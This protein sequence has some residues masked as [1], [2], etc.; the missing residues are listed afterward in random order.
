MTMF[1]KWEH[2]T[3]LQQLQCEFSDLY[4]DVY[5]VRPHYVCGVDMD[6]EDFLRKE[7]AV[8]TAYLDDQPC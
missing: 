2:M 7:I 8:L 4:K 1:T 5:G 3:P 6:N